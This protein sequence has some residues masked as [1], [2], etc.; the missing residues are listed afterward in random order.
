MCVLGVVSAVC[1]TGASLFTVRSISHF[2]MELFRRQS[3]L[4]L[5]WRVVVYVAVIA[6]AAS[7]AIG[8]VVALATTRID[9]TNGLGAS[10]RGAGVGDGRG[11]LRSTLVSIE[12]AL[13]MV[14][15]AG[16]GL[17]IA[18]FAHV[19]NVDGGFR[20]EGVYTAHVSRTPRTYADQQSSGASI[21][22][23]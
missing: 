3:Q 22:A 11:R 6:T 2:G 21:N 17:L 12:A 9:L 23:C 4:H 5:D 16:A 8:A 18:S 20:R 15:L 10:A 1:A 7:L 19:L 13:A 14:L